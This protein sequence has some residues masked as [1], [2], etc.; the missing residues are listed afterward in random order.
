MPNQNDTIR[1]AMLRN[2]PTQAIRSTFGAA[3]SS[4]KNRTSTNDAA[5]PPLDSAKNY[6]VVGGSYLVRLLARLLQARN[7][8][9]GALHHGRCTTIQSMSYSVSVTPAA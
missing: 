3:A 1:H 2:Q 9:G 6:P 5:S 7:V 4:P 8:L